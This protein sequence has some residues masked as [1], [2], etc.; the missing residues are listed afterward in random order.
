LAFIAAPLP[1][2]VAVGLQLTSLERLEGALPG[3]IPKPA[4]RGSQ[5]WLQ[6]LVNDHPHVLNRALTPLFGLPPDAMITWHS[7]LREDDYAEYQDESFLERLGVTLPRRSLA[8]FW[9]RRGPVWDGLGTTTRGDL[10]LVEAKSHIPELVSS[11]TASDASLARIR[12]TLDEIRTFLGVKPR[13]DWTTGLYQ[14][15]NRLAYLYLLRELNGLP[16]YLVHVYFVNDH[17]QGGPTTRA[18]WQS[19]LLLAKTLMGIRR[20]R[21]TPF[22]LDVFVDLA[23]LGGL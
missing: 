12:A 21:L 6:K 23:D 2:L 1:L 7:P 20:H 17:E 22:V 15:A 19:A 13:L 11:S 3:I 9:P 4:T 14:Y 16:A 10:L 5:L 8:D 18:E